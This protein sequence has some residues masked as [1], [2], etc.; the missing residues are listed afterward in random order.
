MY[1][2]TTGTAAPTPDLDA[3]AKKD[4]FETL[5]KRTFKRK[6]A[7]VRIQKICLQITV[8]ALMQPLQYYLRDPATMRPAD[9]ALRN[10]KELRAT[11]SE[12]AAPKPDLDAKA[13]KQDEAHEPECSHVC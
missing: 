13:K 2:I 1:I 5:F 11:A 10:T 6:I 3:K 8:A 4:D 7:S 9:T 12:I